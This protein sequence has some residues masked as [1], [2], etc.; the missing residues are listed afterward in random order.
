MGMF[1]ICRMWQKT[2][3]RRGCQRRQEKHVL[4]LNVSN[5]KLSARHFIEN[6][7]Q[8]MCDSLGHPGNVQ[9][10][11]DGSADAD[12][13]NLNEVIQVATRYHVSVLCHFCEEPQRP[14]D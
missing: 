14:E 12:K 4:K 8:K 9:I 10:D 7:G 11:Y 6:F 3:R 2:S 1:V 13:C 5:K